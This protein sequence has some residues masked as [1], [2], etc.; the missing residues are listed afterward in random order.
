MSLADALITLGIFVIGYIVLTGKQIS[1]TNIMPQSLK[2]QLNLNTN[3]LQSGFSQEFYD[4]VAAINPNTQSGQ[5]I[6][7][8]DAQCRPIRSIGV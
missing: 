8:L 2:T 5:Y 6:Q 4:R 7:Q 3:T 1:F